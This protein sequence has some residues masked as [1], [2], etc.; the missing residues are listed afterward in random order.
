MRKMLLIFSAILLGTSIA[1]AEYTAENKIIKV[2]IPQSS[3]SGLGIVYNHIE[4]YARKQNINMIPVFKPGANAKI[5]LGYASEQKNDG[6]TLVFSTLSDFVE[7]A[8]DASFD[9]VAPVTKT[10]LVLVASSKSNI[11]STTDIVAIE[12]ATPGKL[13]WAYAS[14][15]QSVL[16]KSVIRANNLDVNKV[17]MVPFSVSPGFQTSIGNGDVDL[18]FVLPSIAEALVTKGYATAIAIDDNTHQE[19]S[20]KEN[21]TALFL[22][23]NTASD[24]KMFWNKFIKGLEH[25]ADFKQALKS[26][27]S[28]IYKN[29]DPVDL[30][31]IIAGWKM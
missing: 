28:N 13:T 6:N 7:S 15:A 30:E 20:K 10:A 23:K 1:H 21:G 14:S 4:A 29:S 19:M 8:N 22:P 18:G 27:R 16:I 2:V 25:D 11:K 31:K 26:M 9:K 3:T 5:G 24:A 17:H 12:R